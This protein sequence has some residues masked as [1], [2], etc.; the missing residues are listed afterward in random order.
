MKARSR[1]EMPKI[2]GALCQSWV[3]YIQFLSSSLLVDEPSL[4]LKHLETEFTPVL[5]SQSNININVSKQVLH[6][7][8]SQKYGVRV[9]VIVAFSPIMFLFVQDKNCVLRPCLVIGKSARLAV[10]SS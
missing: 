6:T 8:S 2:C 7:F 1:D 3:L 4:K 5:V 10:P 9:Y